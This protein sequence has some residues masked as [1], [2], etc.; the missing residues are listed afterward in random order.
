LDL[1]EPSLLGA[2]VDLLIEA[3]KQRVR[4]GSAPLW[5]EC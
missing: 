1:I 2:F 3:F 5:R 4:K